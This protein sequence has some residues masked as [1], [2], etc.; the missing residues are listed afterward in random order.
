MRFDR[1]LALSGLLAALSPSSLRAQ[2]TSAARC[3]DGTR[4]ESRYMACWF[5]GGVVVASTP[6]PKPRAA[7]PTR[8]ANLR[9]SPPPTAVRKERVA[10]RHHKATSKAARAT[11]PPKGSTALCKDGSYTDNRKPK[12]G[13]KKHDGVARVLPKSAKP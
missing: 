10:A 13:C 3:G 11:K 5:H 2:A 8:S 9:E 6:A 12:K 4:A 1:I 7:A